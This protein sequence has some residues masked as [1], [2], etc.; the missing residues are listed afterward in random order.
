MAAP[1]RNSA[2]PIALKYKSVAFYAE[3][4]A[5]TVPDGAARMSSETTLVSSKI[6]GAL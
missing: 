2:S 6:M 1:R 3:N 5:S 4:H